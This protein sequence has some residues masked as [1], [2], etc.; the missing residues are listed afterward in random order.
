MTENIEPKI[1][2]EPTTN[3]IIFLNLNKQGNFYLFFFSSDGTAT[4]HSKKAF[5]GIIVK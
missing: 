2:K 4:K 5:K 1:R 3:A